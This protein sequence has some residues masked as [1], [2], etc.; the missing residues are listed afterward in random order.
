[1]L[2]PLQLSLWVALG[3]LFLALPMGILAA[4]FLRGRRF[5]GRSA[6]EGLLLLP[7]VLPPVVT[8]LLLLLL[9]GKRGPVGQFLPGW[10]VQ[11]LFSPWAAVLASAI[12]AFPLVYQSARAAFEGVDCHLEEAARSLGAPPLRCFLTIS[13]PLAAPGLLAGA[14]LA[15]ARAL[16]EF[17]ATVMVAGNVEG[18]TLTAPVAIYFAAENGEMGRAG[19]YAIM[20]GV[21]NLGFLF[22]VSAISNRRSHL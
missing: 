11:I 1:M 13:V 12:V 5:W 3:A 22:V 15:F 4:S 20:L 10:G 2:H 17:G 18:K 7:L 9:L 14:I 8:G 19:F 16:G 21:L 6:L